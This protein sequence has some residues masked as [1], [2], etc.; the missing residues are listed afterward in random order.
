[1]Y[2]KTILNKQCWGSEWR[3]WNSGILFSRIS[4]NAYPHKNLQAFFINI[5][6][7]FMM[8]VASPCLI[9]DLHHHFMHKK[10]LIPTFARILVHQCSPAQNEVLPLIMLGVSR[11]IWNEVQGHAQATK[12]TLPKLWHLALRTNLSPSNK[13]D[14][15]ALSS[16]NLKM[17]ELVMWTKRHIFRRRSGL[18]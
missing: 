10:N 14:Y 4:E 11:S 16:S 2:A 15:I 9:K 8:E 5:G 1:M 12:G 17:K 3:L 6:K 18:T 7:L 13:N